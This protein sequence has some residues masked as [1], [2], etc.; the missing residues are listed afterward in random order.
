MCL[1]SHRNVNTHVGIYLP[2]GVNTICIIYLYMVESEIFAKSCI[3]VEEGTGEGEGGNK[4][5]W[6][7]DAG[8]SAVDDWKEFLKGSEEVTAAGSSS[9]MQRGSCEDS[10]SRC[11]IS[12]SWRWCSCRSPSSCCGGPASVCASVRPPTRR[13]PSAISFLEH[14]TELTLFDNCSAC[15]PPNPFLSQWPSPPRLSLLTNDLDES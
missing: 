2:C 13:L 11:R 14:E 4:T 12:R 5:N 1:C 10:R 3:Q 8:G 15:G 6:L 7:V 9:P